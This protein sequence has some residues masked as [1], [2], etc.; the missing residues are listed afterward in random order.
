VIPEAPYDVELLENNNRV[1]VQ[2]HYTQLVS[3]VDDI[4]GRLKTPE[5]AKSLLEVPELLKEA[6]AHY[7]MRR[8]EVTA[9]TFTYDDPSD[10]RYE[11]AADRGDEFVCYSVVSSRPGGRGRGSP[12]DQPT[13]ELRSFLREEDEDLD[14]PG[15]RKAAMGQW[16]DSVVRLACWSLGSRR[17]EE[18]AHWVRTMVKE[19]TWWFAM[20]GI[21]RIYFWERQEDET[22][23]L[24]GNKF[25]VKSLDFFV[26]TEEISIVSEKTM[27]DVLVSIS[28]EQY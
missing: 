8:A 12:L 16:S 19:Y 5:P 23:N 13:V 4:R 28:I 27:E 21:T 18:L 9:P 15:Y 7:G 6:M 17:A 25:Y 11:E 20:Q 24:R 14:N 10:K 3:N 2:H 22:V 26:K 1:F